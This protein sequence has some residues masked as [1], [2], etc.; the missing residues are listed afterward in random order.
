M[1]MA[2]GTEN[3]TRKQIGKRHITE[4]LSAAALSRAPVE[5]SVEEKSAKCVVGDM[6]MPLV[7]I[8]E[9]VG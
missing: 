5:P 8:G 7:Y 3:E 4:V 9:Q 1:W 2:H 6:S